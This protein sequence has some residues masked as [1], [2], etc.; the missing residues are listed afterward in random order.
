VALLGTPCVTGIDRLYPIMSLI[1]Y[2]YFTPWPVVSSG[3]VDQR[4]VFAADDW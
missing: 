1:F 3:R 4:A 2:F